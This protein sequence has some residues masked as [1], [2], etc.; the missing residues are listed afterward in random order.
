MS[1][2]IDTIKAAITD[3]IY[4]DDHPYSTVLTEARKALDVVIAE[5]ARLQEENASLVQTSADLCL[6][7]GWRMKFPGEGC[8]KCQVDRLKQNAQARERVMNRQHD[9]LRA[10]E[11][12]RDDLR[13]EVEILRAELGSGGKERSVVLDYLSYRI[14]MSHYS[15]AIREFIN[16]R[17]EIS[18]GIHHTLNYEELLP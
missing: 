14:E 1:L 18:E 7:C 10:A 5:V 4:G 2:D 6:D 9:L 15:D 12:E 3:G 11:R 13:R 17:H 8:Q 16:A